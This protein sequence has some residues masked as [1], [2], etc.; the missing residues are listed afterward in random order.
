MINPAIRTAPPVKAGVKSEFFSNLRGARNRL[1]AAL[2]TPRGMASC[3]TWDNTSQMRNA[4]LLLLPTLL[5]AG[6]AANPKMTNLEIA[7]TTDTG[8]PLESASV[9]VKFIEGRSKIKFGTKIREEWDLKTGPDGKVKVP[10]IPQGKILI[11]VINKNY[12]TFGQTFDVQDEQKTI[13]VKLKP[14]QPQYTSHPQ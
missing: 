4:I 9:I 13:D 5:A 14:P 2:T 3:P 12:Q 10:P 6:P 1:R 7:V 11:Q 8:R